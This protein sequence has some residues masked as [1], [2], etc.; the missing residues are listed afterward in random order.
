MGKDAIVIG[1]GIAGLTT[2]A[3]LTAKGLRVTVLEQNW[4]PGG[5]TSSYPR[6]GYIFESGATT[7][8]GLDSGMPL[9]LVLD[10]TGIQLDAIRLETPMRVHLSDGEV[11]TRHEAMSDWIAEAER[12][13]GV[14]GQRAFWE[15]CLDVAEQVWKT[16]GRQLSF[17]PSQWQDLIG[18]A[19]GFAF[20]QLGLLPHAFSSLE[21]LLKRHGLAENARFRAFV[22]EQ[23]LIT[24]QN[25]A[26]EVNALFGATALCYTNFG[27]YYL[28]G[29]MIELVRPFVD[30]I[31]RGGG[32][33][34]LRH[35]VTEVKA[36]EGGYVIGTQ[37]HGEFRAPYLVSG[38]PLNNTL[39]MFG[40]DLQER[41]ESAT[42]EPTR[43]RSAFTMGIVFKR[44]QDFDCLHHQ[45][46]LP[47]PL[48]QIGGG[49]IF[50]SLSHPEDHLRSPHGLYVGSV[51][52]HIFQPHQNSITNKA[53]IEAA[54]VDLLVDRG[55]F[56]REDIVY[57]HSST[58]KS[59]EKWTGRA[60]G[61]VGGYPQ[62]LD[63]K[64][65]QMKDARLDGKGAY[66]CGDSTYPGQGIP[67]ACLS[68]II[69]YEKMRVDHHL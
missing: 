3:L 1:A 69:A 51:S 23:L 19:K 43:L 48:P 9:R 40:G 16:S 10:R 68:G 30:Y 50:L 36:A 2:A 25:H 59:W 60:Y 57:Q 35:R 33:V 39:P 7:L 14:Q 42:M 65:W 56:Q 31:E 6:H 52:T 38:I 15:Q 62:Y 55:F 24:A 45:V 29:G 63:I 27:N 37:K 34:L 18:M 4:L 49:S 32:K 54:V 20:G 44:K 5:C 41:W 17:P 22:D 13:F 46:H 28:P 58:Q 8:V 47:E 61:F 66:I 64:P 53:A 12:V 21:Q 11:I 67:G 26:P